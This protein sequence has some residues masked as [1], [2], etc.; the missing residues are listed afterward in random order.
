[1]HVCRWG[2][3]YCHGYIELHFLLHHHLKFSHNIPITE[4]YFVNIHERRTYE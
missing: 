1:M 2:V 4:I 3:L